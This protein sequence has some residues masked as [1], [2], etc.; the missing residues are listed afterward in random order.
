M[1][2]PVIMNFEQSINIRNVRKWNGSAICPQTQL[3][4]ELELETR[5]SGSSVQGSAHHCDAKVSPYLELKLK[6]STR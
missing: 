2:Q 6:E 3:M 1:V 5:S 4:A